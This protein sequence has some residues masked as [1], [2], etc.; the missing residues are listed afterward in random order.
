MA[1]Q[2]RNKVTS[3]PPLTMV[4]VLSGLPWRLCP[5]HHRATARLAYALLGSRLWVTPSMCSE[6]NHAF[7]LLVIISL[8]GAPQLESPTSGVVQM[9]LQSSHVCIKPPLPGAISWTIL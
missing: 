6:A 9:P 1:A 8:P 3:F 5:W 7:E 2:T 4:P